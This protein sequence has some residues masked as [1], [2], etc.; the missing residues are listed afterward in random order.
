MAKRGV[1]EHPKTLDL[2]CTLGIMDCFALGILEAFWHH[3]GKYHE[4]GDMTGAKPAMVA[5][6][7]R[8]TGDAQQL[9][10]ALIDAGF[11]DVLPDGRTLVHGWS[12]HADDAV[13]TRL[14]RSVTPFADGAKPKARSIGIAEK[15]R[16]DVLWTESGRPANV[17]PEPVPEPEPD[18]DKTKGA[19]AIQISDGALGQNPRPP[20]TVDVQG[21]MNLLGVP[22]DRSAEE[23]EKYVSDRK[24]KGW[25][26][27]NT[28]I[29]DWREDVKMWV[30]R[31]P[32]FSRGGG[33]SPPGGSRGRESGIDQATRI[34]A[35]EGLLAR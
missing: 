10:D 11:L 33:T 34:L 1:L 13:H 25:K 2:A 35:Q 29:A 6:S 4:D 20:L 8:Y 32:E 27:G 18:E 22:P 28:Q 21:Y 19:G 14:Y 31:M 12:E 5:R 26:I 15:S 16:L 9:W 3:V 24:R 30:D 17:L 7:I 23:A